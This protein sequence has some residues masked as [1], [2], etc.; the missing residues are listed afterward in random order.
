[1]K[2]LIP[3]IEAF[4]PHFRSSVKGASWWHVEYLEEVLGTSLPETY[5]SFAETFADTDGGLLSDC[6]SHHPDHVAKLYRVGAID[7]PSHRYLFVLGDPS[8][9]S[10]HYFMDLAAMEDG[11]APVFRSTL[12]DLPT[13][14]DPDYTFTSLRELLYHK[15]YVHLRLPQLPHQAG[16]VDAYRAGDEHHEES[17][18]REAIEGVEALFSR[19]GF[20][21]H[22][23]PERCRLYERGDAAVALYR[24]PEVDRFSFQIGMQEETEFQEM[25]ALLLDHLDLQQR[26]LPSTT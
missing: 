22:P 9:T 11:D 2:D 13:V 17:A 14:S 12:D 4:D 3:F 23:F 8:F 18:G 25:T 16:F 26:N 21:R 1:M 24:P 20:D 10:Q 7:S 15:A 6:E 19:I 5:V